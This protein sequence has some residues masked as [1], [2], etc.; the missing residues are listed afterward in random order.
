M[1]K[2]L[3]WTSMSISYLLNTNLKKYSKEITINLL[4]GYFIVIFILSRLHFSPYLSKKMAN[5]HQ[6][7]WRLSNEY[8]ANWVCIVY[9]QLHRYLVLPTVPLANQILPKALIPLADT[10]LYEYVWISTKT[11]VNFIFQWI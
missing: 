8:V 10:S 6:D 2:L 11:M 7:R 4:R 1:P 5:H 9:T 3:G